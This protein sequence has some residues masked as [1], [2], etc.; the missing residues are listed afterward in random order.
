M[1]IEGPQIVEPKP[2]RI[3]RSTT[4]ESR[5]QQVEVLPRRSH[6]LPAQ[7]IICKRMQYIK[8]TFNRAKAPEKLVRCETLSGGKLIEAAVAKQDDSLLLDI[9][10]KDLVAIEARYHKSCFRRY[11]RS[12]Q[13]SATPNLAGKN[14]YERGYNSFCN[15]V[16][17]GRIIKQK[18]ILRL[19]HM[20]QLFVKEVMDVECED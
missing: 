5:N 11:T 10:D 9:R 19:V 14:P 2:N 12:V 1:E 4:S 15:K 13:A 17:E 8:G 3:L 16:V 20:K 18:E 6:V 7:C